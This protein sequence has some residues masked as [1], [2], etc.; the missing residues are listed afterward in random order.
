[1]FSYDGLEQALSSK[2]TTKTKMAAALG[3]SSRTIAKIG[4]GEKLSQRTLQR[5]AAYLGCD[6]DSLCRD[7]SESPAADSGA[8]KASR[9]GQEYEFSRQARAALEG[10][11]QPLAVYQ[12]IHKQV[13]T[14]LVSDGFCRM[15]G[16][17]DRSM[18]VEKMNHNMYRDIHPDDRDRV[19]SSA[20]CFMKNG[21]EYDAVFRTKAGVN[22]DY[23]V[24]HAH[25]KHVWTETGARL[26]QIW[27]MDEG[28][29]IEGD[30]SA[31]AGMIRE[32]NSA[33]HEESI[34]KA[35][36]YDGLTGLPNLAYF[37]KLCEI[38]KARL[39]SEGKHGCLLYIDLDGMKYYNQRYGFA[40][41]DKLLQALSDLL[42]RT[43]GHEDCCHIAA[44]RFAVS[45]TEEGL[46][47]RLS[48][49]LA[50]VPK[51]NGGS[52]LPVRIGVY[53][54][55]ME[56]VPVSS[57]FD[58]AKMAC[59]TL[60]PSDVSAWKYYSPEIQ[61]ANRRRRYIQANIDR[62]VSEKWIKVHCQP[63]IRAVN[64]KVCDEEALAR[65]DDPNEGF[66]SP[67]EFIPQLEESGQIYKLDL[68]VLEQV[69]EK[70][71]TQQEIGMPVVPHSINLSRSDFDAC[72]IV[73]EIR[74]RVD[75]AGVERSLI[76]VEITE[77]VVGSDFDFMK[78]QIARFRKLG[79]PVWM[80]D[81]GTGYSSLDVLQSIQFDLIKFDMS[82]MRKLNDGEKP[83]IIL[84][85]LMK[86]ANSLGVDTVCE[87]VE[88]EEQVRFL[89]EI[90][91]SKLQGFYYHKP[92]LW[93]D[94]VERFKKGLD[95]GFED[96]DASSYYESIGRI[97]LNDLDVI[98]SM[99]GES[100]RRSFN[101]MPMG[102]VEI[103]GEAARFVRI[104][105]SYREFMRR[106]FG[107]DMST[108]SPDFLKY[109]VQFMNNI[110]KKCSEPGSRTFYDEKMADGSVVHSF[111]RRIASNPVS[112]D[113]AVAIAVLSISD[114]G[115]GES[116]A[117]I[118]R[119]L[120][121][122]YYNIYVVDLD[123][124]RYIAY[125]SPVGV[126]ELADERH[127][128]DFFNAVKQDAIKRIY[129]GD[130]EMF[131]SL[132][133][134]ENILRELDGQGVFT[135]TCR[136]IDTGTPVYVNIKV[137]RMQ[138][139]NRIIMGI[140]IIDAQTRQQERLES[141]L[142]ERNA[143]ARVM[144]I[145]ED[146]LSL[147]S[148]SVETGKYIE[149][150]AA[151]EYETLGFEK[152]GA[153]FFRQG[154]IDGKKAVYPEDLPGYLRD[155]TKENVLRKIREEGRFSIHYRLVIQGEPVRVSL[156]IS[157]FQDGRDARLLAGV[158]K[159]RVR[160]QNTSVPG[161]DKP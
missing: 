32:L 155:F 111:A 146:Y 71:R 60:P 154:I 98:T 23:R 126:D 13:N 131:M 4:K 45:T 106:F 33:L 14:L 40:A 127:G 75:G 115:E 85:E 43:F 64:E 48:A 89:Q 73:E 143:L 103:R 52:H 142:R 86:M 62:A 151:A 112:G 101:T 11:Q 93:T 63:I 7:L 83:R 76:T 35:A 56:D 123:T 125:T 24:V 54:T 117:D 65:W 17:A 69:L 140:S 156:K 34:L 157:P 138:G 102:I 15:F 31:G 88:T 79:F 108:L 134:R 90:G 80:D 1:M 29:Y 94:I 68:Y 61:E 128:Q 72:D 114:P 135:I 50:E 77:S 2:K 66:L 95:V 124:D 9:S 104:N 150:T 91:C 21:G 84:T 133:T 51:I 96:P 3:I 36:H 12:L 41:G 119:A 105:P 57:A 107:F 70:I 74:K 87:G 10:L 92:M 148:V 136:I 159:W 130:R 53:T 18:A 82:F 118:A 139:T 158:R 25:G 116:Y 129:E 99:G 47:D 26:A 147:Y 161:P 110:V 149:Y 55:S 137:T 145:S 49:F 6:A 20:R 97:N 120:A 109:D 121:A 28:R 152:E 113:A 42:V 58:R 141:V 160:S 81:F 67:A 132:F 153:D 78:E 8:R 122:D 44:D 5:I 144:A 16:H 59:D 22:S 30:E 37:F 100:F 39:L 19:I 27:Y 38:R 46:E